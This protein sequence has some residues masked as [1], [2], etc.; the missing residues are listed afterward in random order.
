MTFSS[1]Q[2][3]LHSQVH[4]GSGTCSRLAEF[5]HGLGG[6][7]VV[8]FTDKGL[9]QAGITE[10]IKKLLDQT[11]KP[12]Q[13]VG[14]FDEI[15]QD[16]KG[17]KINR[18]AQFFRDRQADALIA[19]G[20]GSVLDTVKGVKWLLH[21]GK[22]DIHESLKPV[23]QIT[24]PEAKPIPIPHIA[25]PTTAGTGSEVSPVAVIFH[26]KYQKK[27]NLFHPY[28]AADIAILDPELTVSLPPEMTAATGMDALTHA[29]EAFF[30]PTAHPYTDAFAI[31]AMQMILKHLPVAVEDGNNLEAREQMLIASSMAIIAFCF[32]LTAVPVHNLSHA[33]GARFGIPHGLANAVLLP[34]VME[35]LPS[36]YQPRIESFSKIIGIP[37]AIDA[38]TGFLREFRKNVG[39]PDTFAD[40]HF[41]PELE[42]ELV[43]LVK[44]DPA[45]IYPIPDETILRIVREVFDQSINT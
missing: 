37:P 3:F 20:G 42:Q 18:A 41:T 35:G 17:E 14:I 25:I 16:A 23:E 13:L 45:G 34:T 5:V 4:S 36:F 12:V 31:Q 9:T 21:L 43:S 22:Q 27:A 10:K 11:V 38:V 2:F 33:L 1:F 29:V 30:S 40:W 44:Q 8:L 6:K 7:R 39:L 28:I 19:L 32:S 26:E 24:L 15:E